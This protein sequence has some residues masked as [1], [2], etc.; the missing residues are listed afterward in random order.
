MSLR[1]IAH[2]YVKSLTKEEQKSIK[3]GT[4]AGIIIEDTTIV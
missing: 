2:N 1:F 4:T 3:G